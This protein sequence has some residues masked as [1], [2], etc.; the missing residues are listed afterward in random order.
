MRI[1][2]AVL[3]LC[4]SLVLV[5]SSSGRPGG[6]H[7]APVVA[8]VAPANGSTVSGTVSLSATERD[9]TGIAYGAWYVDNLAGIAAPNATCAKNTTCTVSLSYDTTQLANGSHTFHYNAVDNDSPQLVGYGNTVTLNVS[10]NTVNPPQWDG[11][12]TRMTCLSRTVADDGVQCPAG[13]WSGLGFID[14]DVQLVSDPT[15]TQVYRHRTKAG[16]GNGYYICGPTCG[17]SWLEHAHPPD[18]GTT[19]W[20][21]DTTKVESSYVCTSWGVLLQLNYPGLSSPPMTLSLNCSQTSTDGQLH[22]GLDRNAGAISCQGCNDFTSYQH[23]QLNVGTFMDKWVDWVIGIHWATDNT[24]WFE[25]YSRTRANGESN[26]TLRISGYNV[27]TMQYITGQ[28]LPP[29][30]NDKQDHYFGYWTQADVPPAGFPT[31]YVDHTGLMR[32]SDQL[33]AVA[34]RG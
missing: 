4:L 19:I 29:N 3:V 15:Y 9:D 14:N 12:A 1:S 20:Y 18:L 32:F 24:G 22:Y 11:S 23:T 16:S 2:A 26:F 7:V 34:S 6:D 27:P 25:Y 13:M 17:A 33:S 10:N 5:G 31:N 28:P 30:A 8:W 21:A